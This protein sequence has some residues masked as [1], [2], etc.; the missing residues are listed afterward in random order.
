LIEDASIPGRQQQLAVEIM[1]FQ[2]SSDEILQL[3]S[4]LAPLGANHE[5]NIVFLLRQTDRLRR[6]RFLWVGASVTP[7]VGHVTAV[8]RLRI[9]SLFQFAA[10]LEKLVSDLPEHA[11]ALLLVG[12]LSGLESAQIDRSS[13]TPDE[14][15][16]AEHG[17]NRTKRTAV[18]QGVGSTPVVWHI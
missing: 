17:G 5:L 10:A 4:S 14:H 9:E 18:G 8:A 3:C 2:R 13:D 15:E 7:N 16:Q 6:G 12:P 1:G 11:I